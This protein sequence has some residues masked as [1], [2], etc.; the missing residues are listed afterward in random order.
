MPQS[1]SKA[2]LLHGVNIMAIAQTSDLNPD[3]VNKLINSVKWYHSVEILPDVVAPGVLPSGSRYDAQ[4]Y[5]QM[6]ED[7][8]E[9]NKNIRIL[10]IATW[11]GPVAYE[12]KSLGYDVQA[13]DI[14]NPD[15]TGFNTVGKITGL[16]V[17]YERCSVYE[18]DKIYPKDHFD[19]VMFM[20]VFYHL[21]HPLLA[22]EKV[23]SVLKKD[24]KLLTSGSGLNGHFETNAG[25]AIDSEK[26]K[27][28][29]ELLEVCDEADVPV[30]FSFPGNFIRGDNWFMPSKAALISWLVG[31]GFTV[32]WALQ[33]KVVGGPLYL[34]ARATKQ[35]D[36]SVIEHGLTGEQGEYKLKHQL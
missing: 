8:F 22:F 10:E 1:A 18:L 29:N 28:I 11:D 14:Q 30:C 35:S 4:P 3:E 13:C 2:S 25:V 34:T 5:I 19:L 31:T 15:K 33:H 24:G 21:K 20:G 16:T 7:S 36:E 9:G 12:L 32:D 26:A 17:P 27:K 23:R 6:V